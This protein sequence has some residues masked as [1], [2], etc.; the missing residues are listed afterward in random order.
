[1]ALCRLGHHPGLHALLEQDRAVIEI[2]SLFPTPLVI[3]DLSEVA[4]ALPDLRARIL[5]R[6]S[7]FKGVQRSNDGGWQSPGDFPYWGGSGATAVLEAAR[8]IADKMTAL[9]PEPIGWKVHAWA[10]VS[11]TGD[12]NARHVHGGAIWS[13]IFYVD[14]GG[15]AGTSA[16]GGGLELW[17][18]RGGLPLMYA[19]HVTIL[20]PGSVNAGLAE[21]HYPK[22]GQLL[23]FPSWLPHS[24]EP[25]RGDA[26][27]ISVAFNFSL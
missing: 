2:K 13:G 1:M 16:L 9:T 20:T 7:T 22:A 12:A 14:D 27:R 21:L 4:P 6:E 23:M 5:E 11:R 15:I 18:P 3:V 24:V 25:Y 8:Q 10:N 26:V 17:D 19:P